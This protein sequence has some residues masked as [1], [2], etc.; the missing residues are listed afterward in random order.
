MFEVREPSVIYGSLEID[1]NALTSSLEQVLPRIRKFEIGFGANNPFHSL[2]IDSHCYGFG[3]HLYVKL[4][5]EH[6]ELQ[7]IWFDVWKA[8]PEE[9]EALQ[10]AFGVIEQYVPS[11]IADYW[12]NC[13][14]KLADQNFIKT[15][16]QQFPEPENLLPHETIKKNQPSSIVMRLQN[17]LRFFNVKR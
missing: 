11:M 1:L 2:E 17:L 12:L 16:F 14:G 13:S 3:T 8:P 6:G 15:Y 10:Q 5:I 7:S 9:T 4:E